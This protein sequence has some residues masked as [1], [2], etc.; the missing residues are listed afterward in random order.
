VLA[1][2]STLQFGHYSLQDGLPQNTV[3][4]I[5]QDHQG[6][7]WFATQDGLCRYDGYTVR[8]F[9]HRDGDPSTPSSNGITRLYVSKNGLL[10]IGTFDGGLNV[11]DHRTG[12]FTAYKHDPANPNSVSDN[13]IQAICE[14]RYGNMWIGT[15]RGGINIFFSKQ[16]RWKRFAHNSNSPSALSASRVYAVLEDRAGTVWISTFG[17]GLHRFTPQDSSFV[18]YRHDPKN[19]QSL[20]SDKVT[21]LFQDQRGIVWV[22]TNGGGLNRFDAAR[23]ICTR[24]THREADPTSLSNDLVWAVSADSVGRLWVSTNGGLNVYDYRTERF[25]HYKHDAGDPASLSDNLMRGLFCDRSGILWIGTDVGGVNK[26]DPHKRKF[27]TFRRNSS[28]TATNASGLSGNV[29]RALYEDHRQNLWIG[30]QGGG[31]NRFDRTTERFAHWQRDSTNA[32]TFSSNDVWAVTA[33]RTAHNGTVQPDGKLWVGTQE[34]LNLFDPETGRVLSTYRNEP[35]NPRSLGANAVRALLYD[36][37]G[38]LWVGT[39]LGGLNRF[40]ATSRSW[41]RFLPDTANPY[42][43]GSDQVRALCEDPDGTLWVGTGMNGL[44]AFDPRTERFTRFS[45]NPNNPRSLSNNTVRSLLVA[46][47]GTLWVGTMVGLNKFDRQK[48]EFTVFNERTGLPNGIIYGIAEDERGWLWLSTNKGLAHFNPATNECRAYEERDGLQSNEFNG[49]AVCK[50]SDGVLYFGG[51]GGYTAFHPDSIR[52]TRYMPPVRVTNFTLFDRPLTIDS[53][54]QYDQTLRLAHNQ[55]FFSVEFA[56]LDYSEPARNRY[57]Y[58]L[59]G[60]DADWIQSGSRRLAIY[61]ALA[62]GTYVLR[63]RGTNSNGVWSQHELALPIIITPPFWRTWWFYSFAT[64]MLAF[65]VWRAYRWRVAAIERRNRVLEQM[66]EHRTEALQEANTQLQT[67]NE[68]IQRHLFVLEE[69]AQEILKANDTLHQQND[70]LTLLNNEKNEFL[71]IAAHDLKNPLNAIMNYA[72]M[73]QDTDYDLSIEDQQGF[74]KHI[75]ESSEQMFELIKNLLDVNA[76]ERGGIALDI[77]EIDIC[78]AL[79]HVVQRYESRAATKAIH[80]DYQPCKSLMAQADEQYLVQILDNL[81]SNAVKYSPPSNTIFV[82]SRLYNGCAR[83]EIQDQGPGLSAED[84][85]KLFGKFA[86]LSARPTGGEHSTGLGLSIVKKLV[87]AM[88]GRVWCESE[89]GNGATFIVELPTPVEPPTNSL[90]NLPPTP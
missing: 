39:I 86:R 13:A 88:N 77:M 26:L 58:K 7:L 25:T 60:L 74:L 63:L 43:I 61:T 31:L 2:F 6:F 11:Y 53:A 38:T 75:T 76:I 14:D 12:Y 73:L 42:S 30:I 85:H 18:R 70:Q 90:P 24:Y 87:E 78:T 50:G 27:Y 66:V 20:S 52:D 33:H 57:A 62:H 28:Q 41:K 83:I 51:I 65:S 21:A 35:N 84:M 82:R 29:V 34:G 17:G 9:R 5:T 59:E 44:N 45:H 56:A 1:Q 10:W 79:N 19:P 48:Q 46:R 4:N 71:G 23:G 67:A 54:L 37:R 16:Q 40:D 69:Q 81:V 15:E 3:L 36:K 32:Q 89:L 8:I 68:E 80:F 49:A 22:G 55:N 47:D 64:A 72:M